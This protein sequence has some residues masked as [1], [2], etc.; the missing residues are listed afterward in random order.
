MRKSLLLLPTVAVLLVFCAPARAQEAT[1]DTEREAVRRVVETYLYAEDGEERKRTIAPSAKILSLDP[2][3][4]KVIETP[5]SKSAR[6]RKGARE[7]SRQRIVSIDVAEDGASVKVE[8]DLSSET[9]KIPKHIHYLSLLKVGGEWK[10]VGI[11]MPALRMPEAN[12]K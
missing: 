12:A 6:R 5:I 3:G 10:I 8:T 7:K 1:A 11:L 4:S 2:G 9:L